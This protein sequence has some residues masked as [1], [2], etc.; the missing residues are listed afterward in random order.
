MDSRIQITQIDFEQDPIPEPEPY[1]EPWWNN[2]DLKLPKIW[3]GEL[4]LPKCEKPENN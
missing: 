2:H 4:S 1:Q 3:I